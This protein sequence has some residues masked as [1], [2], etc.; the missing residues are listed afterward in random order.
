MVRQRLS[1]GISDIK[2]TRRPIMFHYDFSPADVVE[3]FRTYFGPTQKTF[4]QLNESD[5]AA[6]RADLEELW[7]SKNQATDGTT[8]VESEY[9]E[10]LATKA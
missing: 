6:L 2:L 10:V 1:E 4:E 5:Q 9:L 3:Y 7:S 8:D